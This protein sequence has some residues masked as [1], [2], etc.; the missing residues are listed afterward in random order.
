MANSHLKFVCVLHALFTCRSKTKAV[1]SDKGRN[2]LDWI[3]PLPLDIRWISL[4]EISCSYQLRPN[5][6]KFSNIFSRI[7]QYLLSELSLQPHTGYL[8]CSIPKVFSSYKKLLLPLGLQQWVHTAEHILRIFE[9]Y[10]IN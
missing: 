9:W 1:C 2:V 7:L 6:Y 3:D 5:S 10:K 8:F 4:F